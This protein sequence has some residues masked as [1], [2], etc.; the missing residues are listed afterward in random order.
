MFVSYFPSFCFTSFLGLWRFLI[1]PG[2]TVTSSMWTLVNFMWDIQKVLCLIIWLYTS[3]FSPPA[4]GFP[5]DAVAVRLAQ[6]PICTSPRSRDEPYWRVSLWPVGD[7]TLWTNASA[8]FPTEVLSWDAVTQMTKK[9]AP[10]MS[11]DFPDFS[12]P[13]IVLPKKEIT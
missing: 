7:R 2:I 3:H 1:L 8:F 9:I 5:F 11:K 13:E 10:K 6:C 4:Q 12:L